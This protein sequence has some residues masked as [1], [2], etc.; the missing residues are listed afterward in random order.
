MCIL[1]T[2]EFN[3]LHN[4][5][6]AWASERKAGREG[7]SW[8]IGLRKV[9]RVMVVWGQRLKLCV[10]VTLRRCSIHL[11]HGRYR[12]PES[13]SLAAVVPYFAEEK[14][15]S[16]L[17]LLF[18]TRSSVIS[19]GHQVHLNIKYFNCHVSL[20]FLLFCPGP[21][22]AFVTAACCLFMWEQIMAHL[23]VL[24]LMHRAPSALLLQEQDSPFH[25]KTSGY[26]RGFYL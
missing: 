7:I 10:T 24:V 25:C 12:A 3:R 9:I 23:G 13:I 5:I 15:S 8:F 6:F 18:L 26:W 16:W 2:R 17:A 14:A 22:K 11:Q 20:S 4:V 1:P 21:T 19:T